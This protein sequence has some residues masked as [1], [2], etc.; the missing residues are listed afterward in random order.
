MIRK[1]LEQLED[2]ANPA[3]FTQVGSELVF[4]GGSGDNTVTI[5]VSNGTY[6]FKDAG[7]TITMASG[8]AFSRLN[9]PTVPVEVPNQ[10]IEQ[11]HPRAGI[12][13]KLA[14]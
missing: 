12:R 14:A 11:E 13:Q 1:H 5:S 9:I 8:L 10:Q 7:E 3:T 6:T 2:R 4:T